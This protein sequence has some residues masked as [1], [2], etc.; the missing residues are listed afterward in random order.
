[1]AGQGHHGDEEKISRWCDC[2]SMEEGPDGFLLYRFPN[3]EAKATEVPNYTYQVFKNKKAIKKK[4]A[5]A[6]KAKA[7]AKKPA[8]ME[9]VIA[10]VNEEETPEQIPPAAEGSEDKPAD[11]KVIS[12]HLTKAK[13]KTYIQAKLEKSSGK[14]LLCNL[15]S[16]TSQQHLDIMLQVMTW[17]QNLLRTYPNST[18]CYI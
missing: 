5:A 13:D 8:A 11:E 12:L 16:S 1:M 7:V 9:P 6:G 14:K 15:Q 18:L 17:G 2:C 10:S 3:E 4:P